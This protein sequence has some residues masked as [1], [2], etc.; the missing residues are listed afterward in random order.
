MKA[1]C[2]KCSRG[3]VCM[4]KNQMLYTLTLLSITVTWLAIARIIRMN[5]N[6]R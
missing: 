2:E 4:P 1:S 6:A 5:F 3:N